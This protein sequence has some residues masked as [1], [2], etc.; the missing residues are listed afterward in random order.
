MLTTILAYAGRPLAQAGRTL[1]HAGEPLAPHDLWRTWN[2]DPV[3]LVALAAGVW[4]YRRGRVASA[5]PTDARRARA[6]AG[7]L[8]ALAIALISPLEPLSGALA[9]AHM[10]QHVLLVL[11]AGPLLAVS[12]PGS[13]LLRGSP[14]AVRRARGAAR[15]RFGLRSSWLHAPSHPA[16]VLLLHVGVLWVWHSAAAYDAALRSD[17]VHGVEHVTFLVTAV[18]FW[19]VV[20]GG[21][22]TRRV[23]GGAGVLLVFG[24]AM[25]SVFLSLLLTFAN[26]P[27]YEGYA[28]TTPAWGLDPLADQHL[29]GVLMWVPA[30]AIYVVAALALFVSWIAETE[31]PAS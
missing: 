5:R 10:G 17:L 26:E 23:P 11:V 1:A 29:A 14:L 13:R 9:S 27:W 20:A 16:T 25:A 15:R 8:A 22:A 12:A 3:L 24:A 4:A 19:R 18:L 21:R 7:A 2:V 6:F 30:G 31:E 28:T